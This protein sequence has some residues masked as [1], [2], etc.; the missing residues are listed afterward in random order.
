VRWETVDVVGARG[1]GLDLL[2][3][4]MAATV[5]ER[6]KIGEDVILGVGANPGTTFISMI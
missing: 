6:G 1:N 3:V 5:G 2:G 4:E